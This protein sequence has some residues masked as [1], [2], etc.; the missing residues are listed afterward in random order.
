MI[1]A[2]INEHAIP[3]DGY[4]IAVEIAN[5][6][7]D[8]PDYQSFKTEEEAK[9]M[10]HLINDSCLNTWEDLGALERFLRRDKSYYMKKI[11]FTDNIND[12]K[13]REFVHQHTFNELFTFTGLLEAFGKD[14]KSYEKY[15][16]N[17]GWVNALFHYNRPTIEDFKNFE[18]WVELIHSVGG[19]AIVAAIRSLPIEVM[20]RINDRYKNYHSDDQDEGLNEVF[21]SIIVRAE[22]IQGDDNFLCDLD[23]IDKAVDLSAFLFKHTLEDIA[24]TDTNES[25]KTIID[26]NE[27]NAS[28]LN[29][30]KQG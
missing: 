6:E 18:S 10:V 22:Y 30:I 9:R 14:N 15:K 16:N 25:I 23:K 19:F 24:D 1:K 7:E 21:A 5:S 29:Q 28:S 17:D 26:F 2:H 27:Q 12:L 4:K 13:N 3:S 8:N 20:Q 11:F